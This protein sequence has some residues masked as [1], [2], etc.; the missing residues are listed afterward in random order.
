MLWTVERGAAE[1]MT[2]AFSMWLEIKDSL[3]VK[4]RLVV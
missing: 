4:V 1:P 2:R 3:L